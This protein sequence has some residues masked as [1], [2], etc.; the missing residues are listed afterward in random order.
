LLYT[1]AG[2]QNEVV[3]VAFDPHKSLCATGS[4]DQTAKLW[5]LETGKESCTLKGHEGEIVSLNFNAD[6][7]KILTGSFDGTAIVP[8]ITNLDL[9]YQIRGADSRP[10]GP[11]R[12]D[13]QCSI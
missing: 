7:D 5:D 11:Y 1:F 8:S 3:A 13:F 12:L 9:G 4:M 6:G 10:T 2:H